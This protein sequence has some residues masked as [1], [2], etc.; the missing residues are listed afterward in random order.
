MDTAVKLAGFAV[1]AALL[2]LILR[3]LRPELHLPLALCAGT[4]LLLMVLPALS[5]L[6]DALTSLSTL[7]G[8]DSSY[9][10]QLLRLT[11]IALLMDLAAQTC[12]DAAEDALALKV[13]FAGRMLLLSA[14]LPVL[15]SLL[16][17]LLSLPLG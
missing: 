6:L 8:L 2:S 9:M 5:T 4:L 1:C 17:Q 14:S 15:R 11:G 16:S 13:E 3:Q 7:S 10:R 12:R